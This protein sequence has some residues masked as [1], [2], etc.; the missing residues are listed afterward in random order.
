MAGRQAPLDVWVAYGASDAEV[1]VAILSLRQPQP[2]LTE[3]KL[4]LQA[5]RSA[6]VINFFFFKK[7][8]FKIVFDQD[9]K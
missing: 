4:Y 6:S 7:R 9:F 1:V 2:R 5:S 3:D 8:C